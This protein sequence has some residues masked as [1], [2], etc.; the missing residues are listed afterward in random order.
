LWL[1]VFGI[2][3]AY[4]IWHGD[5]LYPYAII[6][7]ILL[8]LFRLSPR[9]LLIVAAVVTV[10]DTGESVRGRFSLLKTKHIYEEAVKAESAHKT[11]TDEQKTGKAEWEAFK[12]QSSPSSE[13]LKKEREMYSGSYLHLVAKRAEVVMKWHSEPFY[14]QL[15]DMFPM[16][17]I[18]I[19]FLKLGILAGDRSTGFYIKTL[20]AAYAI[21][22]P[23]G[24]YAAFTAWGNGFDPVLNIFTFSTYQIARVAM[25][26]GH[27]S[28]LILFHR[29]GWLP[30]LQAALSS[31]G[32]TAFSNYILHSLIYGFVFYGYGFNLFGKLER[33]QIYYVVAGMWTVSLIVSPLWLKAYRYGPLEWCWR[34]LTYWKRQPMR[35]EIAT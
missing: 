27:M 8:P 32:K 11:L 29:S 6:G 18:G 34:S 30:S 28:L 33:Y 25:T 4:L 24:S 21:G 3:H 5:I 31:I 15:T 2:V 20:L 22:L 26:I 35:L 10:L 9:T 14:L 7:L 16:M 19:A 23:I 13:E 12:K 17:L 1:Q